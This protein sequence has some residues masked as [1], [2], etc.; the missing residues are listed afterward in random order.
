MNSDDFIQNIINN[1][2]KNNMIS[3]A[4]L[5]AVDDTYDTSFAL[6]IIKKILSTEIVDKTKYEQTEV[7][8]DNNTFSDLKIIRPDGKFIKKEQLIELMSEYKTKSLDNN[9]RFY[10]IEYA[11]NL[12]SSSA[13]TI[14]KFL[15]EPENDIVAIL[16]TKN[17]YSV[18]NTIISRCQI[19]NF[20]KYIKK[21]YNEDLVNTSINYI[22][23]LHSKTDRAIAYLSDLYLLKNS[24]LEDIFN[25][26]VLFYEDV[27]SYATLG[28]INNFDSNNNSII[29]LIKIIN[30]EEAVLKI[31][32]IQ[33]MINLLQFNVNSRIIL[34][35]LFVGGE[36]NEV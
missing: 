2:L 1:K 8:I 33:S 18:L 36:E 9:K 7:L 28:T 15:E 6:K 31:K 10:I 20:N 13:N 21:K 12:N 17:V 30:L 11:E 22:D 3:H 35:K 26:W 25:I 27:I 14:L 23:I 16:V 29:D 19:L 32:I 5:L 24:E 4:F 34:D